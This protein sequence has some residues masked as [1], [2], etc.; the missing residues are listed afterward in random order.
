M[1]PPAPPNLKPQTSLAGIPSD[2]A[3]ISA[4]RALTALLNPVLAQA[5]LLGNLGIS[6]PDSHF[7]L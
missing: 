7:T 1:Q 4:P 3:C 2:L 6:A 5:C